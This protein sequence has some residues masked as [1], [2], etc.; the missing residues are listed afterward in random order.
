MSETIFEKVLKLKGPVNQLQ[1]TQEECAELVIEHSRL[2]IGYAQLIK[3]VNKYFRDKTNLERLIEE[4][5]DV[6]LA[7]NQM[8]VV[9]KTY[10]HIWKRI[11]KE[12]LARLARELKKQGRDDDYSGGQDFEGKE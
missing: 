5:V 2:V 4:G 9:F 10:A 11:R 12:K 7:I 8:K 6:E 3:G 1:M